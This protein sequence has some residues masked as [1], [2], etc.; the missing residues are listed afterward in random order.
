MSPLLI[1]PQ[2]GGDKKREILQAAEEQKIGSLQND[3]YEYVV[4][5]L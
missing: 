5:G 3:S 4:Y 1:P 2:A